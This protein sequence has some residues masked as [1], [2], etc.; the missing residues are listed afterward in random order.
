VT[1]QH[2]WALG[3]FKYV[4]AAVRRGVARFAA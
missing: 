4:N 1:G 2:I 3:E